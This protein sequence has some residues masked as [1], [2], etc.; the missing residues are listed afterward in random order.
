MIG[1]VPEDDSRE[2]PFVVDD[3]GGDVD[4]LAEDDGSETVGAAAGRELKESS[5]GL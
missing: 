4:S 1:R 5:P 3:A 2:A